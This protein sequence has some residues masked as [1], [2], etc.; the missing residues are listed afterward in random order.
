LQ[1]YSEVWLLFDDAQKL[2]GAQFNDFW[3]DVVKTRTSIGFGHQTKV[4]IVVSATF[5]QSL[6]LGVFG[7]F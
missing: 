7:G 6:F 5:L 2:Y 4:V 1:A 3:Q